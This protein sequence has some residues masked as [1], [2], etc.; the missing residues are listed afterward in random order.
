M[1]SMLYVYSAMKKTNPLSVILVVLF[2][3]VLLSLFFKQ[4][5][6]GYE[7]EEDD[8]LTKSVLQSSKPVTVLF[9]AKWCGHCK[10]LHPDWNKAAKQANADEKR[11]LRVNVGDDTPEHKQLM[12][13]Y[14]IKGFPTI[15]IFKDGIPTEYNGPRN[16]EALLNTLN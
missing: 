2:A 14:N 4:V 9:Y 13:E 8:K 11:M 3:V 10:D 7:N 15:I 6:E 5:K 16:V 12:K 1:Y